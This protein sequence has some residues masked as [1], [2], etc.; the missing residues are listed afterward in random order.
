[1]YE[2]SSPKEIQLKLRLADAAVRTALVLPTE[3]FI[4]ISA[5]STDLFSHRTTNLLSSEF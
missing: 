1:M 4:L 5:N 2:T 3:A